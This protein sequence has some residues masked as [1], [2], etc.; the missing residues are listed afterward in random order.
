MSKIRWSPTSLLL[1]LFVV[2]SLSMNTVN[3]DLDGIQPQGTSRTP[4]RP[5]V[6]QVVQSI[7]ALLLVSMAEPW[8]APDD[9]KYG[10]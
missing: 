2:F 3:A 5:K 1:I 6:V 10:C 9:R 7:Q 4:P 8:E